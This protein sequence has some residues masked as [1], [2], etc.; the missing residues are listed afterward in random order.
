M[1]RFCVLILILLMVRMAGMSQEF[2]CDVTVNSQQVEGTS[3]S[4]YESLEQS[5]KAYMNETQFSEFHLSS[6]E[7]IVCRMFLVVKGYDDT[8]IKGEL[9]VQ[10]SRPVFNSSYETTLFNFRDNKIEFNYRE[11]DPLRYNPNS[12]DS[13]LTTILNYYAF[14]ML[15]IDFDTFSTNGGQEFYDKAQ[16]IVQ[17]AQS[18]GESGWKTFEDTKN[19]AAVL[20]SYIDNSTSAVR[21][22]LYKYHR[23]GLDVMSTSPDKGRKAITDSLGELEKVV[24][25]SPMSVVLSIFRDSKL[26]EI[27]GVYSESPEEERRKV[28][29][30]L[31]QIYPTET[32]RL[33]KI[34]K[35]NK[36]A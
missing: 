15:G 6:E 33:D 23:L 29:N 31:Q 7:R 14:L 11:G 32:S 9:Q 34:R 22:L 36:D 35:G 2:R 13:N 21:S 18:S 27:V 10:L 17:M 19:R 3:K 4:A 25:A 8:R 20:N 26:D 1:R 12:F 28:Y 5:I 30:L 16:T 24:M